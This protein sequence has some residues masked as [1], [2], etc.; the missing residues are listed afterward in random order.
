MYINIPLSVVFV[1][2]TG[3]LVYLIAHIIMKGRIHEE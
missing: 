1:L 2:T 3:G